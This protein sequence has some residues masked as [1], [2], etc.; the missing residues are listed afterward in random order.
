MKRNSMKRTPRPTPGWLSHA[1]MPCPD[2]GEPLTLSFTRLLTGLPI[3]CSGCGLRIA[4]NPEAN[5]S[6]FQALERARAVLEASQSKR[7]T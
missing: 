2:C 5:R 4:A 6:T 1:Q 3:F 7:E